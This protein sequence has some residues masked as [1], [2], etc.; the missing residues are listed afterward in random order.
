MRDVV[1]RLPALT[2]IR[3]HSQGGFGMVE[4]LAAMTVM[5]IGLLAV[6]GLFQAGIVQLRRASTATTAGAIADAEMERY[7]ARLY[8]TIG[9]DNADVAVVVSDTTLGPAYTGDL[10]YRSDTSPTTTLA[11][12]GITSTTQLTVPVA[13][14]TGFPA[15]P[16]YIIK[17]DSELI[18]ISEGTGTTTWTAAEVGGRG[19]M[20]TAAATHASGA[21]VTQVARVHVVK[22][23]TGTCTTSV[24]SKTVTGADGHSYRVDTY[25]NWHVATNVNEGSPCTAACATGRPT[26]LV[27]IVVRENAAPYRQLARLSSSFD[28]STGL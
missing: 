24:P 14:A 2:L 5:L 11:G 22:C 20:G 26:K 8:E 23:G 18:L 12:S 10:S 1:L 13:S 25:I 4:L 7:R 21:A 16:P 17:V 19:Y 15:S 9:L 6:F 27:T 3:A 28:E